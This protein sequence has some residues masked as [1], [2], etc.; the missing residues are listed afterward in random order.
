MANARRKYAV[1]VANTAQDVVLT[2]RGPVR[3]ICLDNPATV[4]FRLDGT[5][6]VVAADDNHVCPSGGV[7]TTHSGDNDGTITVSLIST[8]TPTVGVQIFDRVQGGS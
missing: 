5:T 3:V 8:G 1:L 7:S 4:Y 6:A 2:G